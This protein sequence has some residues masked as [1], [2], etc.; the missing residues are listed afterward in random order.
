[1]NRWKPSGGG[2]L[3]AL[4]LLALG[5]TEASAYEQPRNTI[6]LGFQGQYGILGGETEP[7]PED[8]AKGAWPSLV[9]T[10]EGLAIR[11]RYNTARNR[12]VGLSFEDQRFRRK[13]GLDDSHP[14]QIQ[15]TQ[16]LAEYYL[17]FARPRKIPWYTVVGAGFHRAAVR[18]ETEDVTGRV[19]EEAY[20]PGIDLTVMAGVGVEYFLSRR[21]TIDLSLRGYGFR[22]E[23]TLSGA[24]ELA[25]GLHYYTK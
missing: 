20:L 1:M 19:L 11:V 12:A 17:Y 9:D 2:V 7:I 18:I 8:P 22:S 6:S 21:A 14:K 24:A 10:G 13:D 3:L 16:V 15:L 4:A 5:I 25:L 23:P